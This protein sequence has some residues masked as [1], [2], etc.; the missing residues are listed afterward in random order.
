MMTRK[1]RKWINAYSLEGKSLYLF[2]PTNFIRV[3]TANIVNHKLF[4]P[5]I[6][7]I[8]TVTTIALALD[9]P[10]NDPKGELSITLNKLDVAF[11]SIFAVG[12]III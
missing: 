9:S 10:L 11:T 6:L 2:T 5:L 12:K 7:I 8:I 3:T 4:D 1:S